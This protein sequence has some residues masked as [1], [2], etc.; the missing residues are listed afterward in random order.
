MLDKIT[1]HSLHAKF[2]SGTFL[3]NV[4]YLTNCSVNHGEV[5]GSLRHNILGSIPAIL[6]ARRAVDVS[7]HG[8]GTDLLHGFRV[9]ENIGFSA[10]MVR[11]LI[12]EAKGLYLQ[13]AFKAAQSQKR[14]LFSNNH[15]RLC[16][17]KGTANIS[18]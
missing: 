2:P 8:L 5:T 13:Y 9:A 6:L 14:I 1:V 3:I 17:K 15:N 11:S 4:R 10:I 16:S 18:I 12:D 7:F